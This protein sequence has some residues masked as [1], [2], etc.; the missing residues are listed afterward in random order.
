M[1][2]ITYLGIVFLSIGLFVLSCGKDDG[3]EPDPNPN[4]TAIELDKSSLELF[5]TETEAILI[6]NLDEFNSSLEWQSSD[7]NVATVNN[8]GVVT[9]IDLGTTTITVTSGNLSASVSVAV[10]PDFYV[11]GYIR[12]NDKNFGKVWKNGKIHS[13]F[14]AG[15]VIK[16]I[17]IN[18]S[19]VFACGLEFENGRASVKYWENEISNDLAND[20]ND[21]AGNGILLKGE[22]VLVAG[23]TRDE[24]NQETAI[25]WE[26]GSSIALDIGP[27]HSGA[28]AHS[29]MVNNSGEYIVGMGR[30]YPSYDALL[31][32]DRGEAIRLSSG[33]YWAEALAIDVWSSGKYVAVGFEENEDGGDMAVVWEEDQDPY[34]LTS[35]GESQAKSVD[36]G[37]D[38]DE[39]VGGYHDLGEVR[40]GKIWKNKTEWVVPNSTGNADIRS[41]FEFED[42]VYATGFGQEDDDSPTWAKVWK[43]NMQGQIVETIELAKEAGDEAY[44]YSILVK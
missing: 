27:E 43:I 39:Y 38:G 26:D 7:K 33:D 25:L 6:G 1:K 31:W 18:D 30:N 11:G 41:V 8:D 5:R 40:Y 28:R 9:G 20:F 14:G 24:N 32:K 19:D 29:L 15:T 34:F 44:A 23:F 35:E 13:S 21:A 3:S 2:K 17:Q 22:E 42:Y 4:P 16:S 37:E 36:I 12:K 10:N